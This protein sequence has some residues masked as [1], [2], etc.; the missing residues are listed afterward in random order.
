MN[1]IL[2][3]GG[4]E[5]GVGHGQERVLDP[6]APSACS[7]RGIDVLGGENGLV[8][9]QISPPQAPPEL[10]GRR[11]MLREGKPSD[12]D[13]RLAFPIV[14]EDEDMFGGSWRRG[15]RGEGRH[16]RESLE[17]LGAAPAPPGHVE[18]AVSLPPTQDQVQAL[19]AA[20]PGSGDT[21]MAAGFVLP[22][23]QPTDPGVVAFERVLLMDPSQ[24]RAALE[25]AQTFLSLGNTQLDEQ[26][27]A[28][29]T[30]VGGYPVP[31]L[32]RQP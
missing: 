32:G 4:G 16:T 7:D 19:V 23:S 27:A 29:Y 5:N 24:S 13:D 1:R 31:D 11:V 22:R 3:D 21:W 26:I 25:L 8:L 10:R 30:A 17:A 9:D 28:Y 12:I 6:A 20:D 18:W 15:W 14:P 2:A